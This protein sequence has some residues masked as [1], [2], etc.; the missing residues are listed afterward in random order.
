LGGLQRPAAVARL[1]RSRQDAGRYTSALEV[2][3]C[4]R[5]RGWH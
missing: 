1:F 2:F 4:G 3:R 5:C